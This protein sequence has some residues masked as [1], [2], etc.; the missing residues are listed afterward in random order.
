MP[1]TENVARTYTCGSCFKSRKQADGKGYPLG[2]FYLKGSVVYFSKKGQ[3]LVTNDDVFCCS[4]C[5]ING[6]MKR[7]RESGNHG[8]PNVPDDRERR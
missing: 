7:L 1:V 5:F 2:W 3:L 6:I 8:K 4:K